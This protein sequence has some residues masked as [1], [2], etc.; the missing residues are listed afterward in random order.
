MKLLSF[1]MLA[2]AVCQLVSLEAMYRAKSALTQ[3]AAVLATVIT[4]TALTVVVL[5][6]L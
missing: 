3:D 1:A 2:L 4:F 5:A 6:T